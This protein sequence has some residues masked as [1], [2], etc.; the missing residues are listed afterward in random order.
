[1]KPRRRGRPWGRTL[2]LV[3]TVS[4]DSLAIVLIASHHLFPPCKRRPREPELVRRATF[5]RRAPTHSPPG[6]HMKSA[7]AQPARTT[8]D[9]ARMRRPAS[10][11]RRWW[12]RRWQWEVLLLVYAAYDGSRL[13]VSGKREQAEHHGQRLLADEH[14]LHLSPEHWLNH[15]FTDHAWLGI[16]ADFAYASLHYLITA[17]VLVWIW[18]RHREHYVHARIWLGLTTL[19]GLVGFVAFPTAPPRMLAPSFGFVDIL[20]QHAS[21][22]WWG[23]GG[24][25]PRGLGAVTNEYAAMP[26]L[27]VGWALWCGLLI[28]RHSRHRPL[29]ILGLLYPATIAVVVM[30]TANHYLLDCLAGAAVALLGLRATA[31]TL[32]LAARVRR[33]RRLDR[34]AVPAHPH[35]LVNQLP[36]REVQ[37][38]GHA[39]SRA[40]TRAAASPD[41]RKLVR[42]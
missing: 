33:H 24:G 27:H 12:R 28:F 5:R 26:S 11:E 3:L 39:D 4:M 38:A 8:P 36:Q 20:A 29:R 19:L 16:P 25:T 37:P 17:G 30:G 23:T 31:P 21:I 18:R 9:N 1:M 22:G 13:L 40:V 15:A 35:Q 7:Y 42:W 14:R 41:I 32:R 10:P 2:A 6:E 34:S